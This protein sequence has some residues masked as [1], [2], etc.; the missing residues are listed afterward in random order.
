MQS[1]IEHTVGFKTIAATIIHPLIAGIVA[2]GWWP[3]SDYIILQVDSY[4]LLSPFSKQLLEDSKL[5]L[6]VLISAAV[7]IKII[8][9]IVNLT[10][11]KTK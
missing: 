7:L 3:A 1:M 11:K 6:G 4:V 10:N 5:I 9:G 8:I 2:L